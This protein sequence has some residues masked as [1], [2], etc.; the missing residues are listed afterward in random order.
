MSK[1]QLPLVIGIGT[2][3]RKSPYYESNLKYGVTGFTVYNKMYLPTAFSGSD[4]EEKGNLQYLFLT[5]SFSNNKDIF[6]SL[7]IFF[8]FCSALFSFKIDWK[9]SGRAFAGDK[10]L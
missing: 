9:R 10:V 8:N 1:S 3:I 2:R 4:K 5:D 7:D 6:N